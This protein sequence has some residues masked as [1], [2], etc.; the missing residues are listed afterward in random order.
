MRYL[1]ILLLLLSLAVGAQ[2]SALQILSGP[3]T[4]SERDGVYSYKGIPY[5]QPPVGNLRWQAPQPVKPWTETRTMTAYSPI[6]PQGEDPL[7]TR[8]L[9]EKQ[10]EDCLYLNVWTPKKRVNAPVMV[11]IHG[12]GFVNGSGSKAIYDGTNL[13]KQGVVLVTINYRL[14]PF[15]FFCHP[16]LA[17]ESAQLTSGNYGLQDQI[18]ALQWVQSNIAIFGGDPKNVTI[19][20]ES[21]GAVSVYCLL[22]SPLAR[23]LFARAIA[24]S[25]AVPEIRRSAKQAEAFCQGQ[26]KQIGIT[27]WADALP[28]LRKKTTADIQKLYGGIGAMPGSSTDLLCV[29]GYVFTE[30]PSTTF[31]A[32]RQAP[33]PLIAG[34]N[35]DE[36]T[37]FSRKGS[38]QSLSAYKLTLSN[39]LPNDVEEIFNHYPATTNE[40]AKRAYADLLGD[41]SFTVTT[42]RAARWHAK[43]NFPTYRYFFTRATAIANRM[44]LRAFHGCEIPY[45]F[46]NINGFIYTAD[47]RQL[48]AAM[49]AL[50]VNFARGDKLENSITT[51]WN[52]YDP[53]RD[54]ALVF[55][56]TIVEKTGIRAEKLALLDAIYDK[57]RGLQD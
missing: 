16:Q 36:G 51:P 20:G 23:G 37:L 54:N 56:T 47:D 12:G 33:V 9:T 45:A 42:R 48:A 21:A 6:C 35:A 53:L 25:G 24:H 39:Y 28:E 49:S 41:I 40:E 50:W 43:A 22:A 52:M 30:K 4:G 32:G 10:S 7:N 1:T 38:P 57:T 8:E 15:G 13:A 34:S 46:N 2:T 3:I 18:A 26:V 17:E 5:A 55:D 29:D 11:W 14:G 44:E 19:F 27:E 31:A